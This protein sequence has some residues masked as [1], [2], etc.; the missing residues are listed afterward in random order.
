MSLELHGMASGIKFDVGGTRFGGPGGIAMK[1]WVMRYSMH[2]GFAVS[3]S[4]V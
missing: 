1:P 3:S 2:D 4:F